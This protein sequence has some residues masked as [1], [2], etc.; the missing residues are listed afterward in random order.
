MSAE[1]GKTVQVV[2][3]GFAGLAVAYF[4]ARRGRHVRLVEKT[5]RHGGLLR[6]MET[7]HGLVETAANALLSNALVEET[8]NDLGIALTAAQ[9]T[10]KKR[11]IFRGGKLRR[12]PLNGPAA[13]RFLTQTAPRFL[14][15]RKGFTPYPGESI[16]AWGERC[17][18]AEATEYLLIPALSGVY[19]GEPDALSA[20][21][22]LGRFF[23]GSRPK[24]K[25]GKLRGSVAPKGGMGEFP[26]A[27]H[28]YLEEEGAEFA[29]EAAPN[30][31]TVVAL[32]PPAAA[33]FLE[34]R[35]PTLSQ[36]L[37]RI[38][39]AS[40]LTATVFLPAHAR[41]IEGFGCLF[42]RPE[43]FRVLGILANDRI[44]AG[45][46]KPGFRSETWI[47]G[48]AT[49][50]AVVALPDHEIESLIA[51]ERTRLFGGA[52]IQQTVIT[53]WPAAIPHYNI[54]LEQE[55]GAL[56]A[57][58]FTENNYVLFGTYLGDLGLARVLTQAE[59]LARRL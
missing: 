21:L 29:T 6:T 42:P 8:A 14:F 32:P 34:A 15:A 3:G 41:G 45:R 20:S 23:G 2:G 35:A 39:M 27:F 16:R 13:T 58:H 22:I 51:G 4:L 40:I 5:G 1:A 9:P 17:I 10:A 25:R 30:L 26:R 43:G 7:P 56:R 31:P 48:G 50:P 52:E 38:E 36:H 46:V 57:L 12:F 28:R 59:A 33:A 24:V 54:R 53:R 49:D 37:A 47:M 55:L 18:G 19:A 11:F 44:F